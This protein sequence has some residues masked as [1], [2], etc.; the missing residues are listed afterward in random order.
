M[1]PL[2]LNGFAPESW[3]HH[4]LLSCAESAAAD[5]AMAAAGT[6]GLELMRRAA[7]AV[8]NVVRKH[9]APRPT[10]V[11]CGP[12]NNGGDGFIIAENLRQA[13]WLVRVYCIADRTKYS[14]DAAQALA[15]WQGD[16]VTF[17]PEDTQLVVDALFG[18]GLNK[19][20]EGE[21]REAIEKINARGLDVV[22]VDIPSGIQGD[23]G[24][25][26][27]AA[28]KARQ[29][30]TFT[31]KKIGHLL[32]PGC[33]LAGDVCVAD[34][35]I[36][37]AALPPSCA[38]NM[39]GL[40]G[41][42][43]PRPGREQHKYDRGHVL[44]LG[45]EVL[46]GAARLAARAAQRGGAGLVT[47]AAPEKAWP[48][49]AAA[50]ES[51]M[52]R[53]MVSSGDWQKLLEDRR[54]NTVVLGPGAGVSEQTYARVA[55]ALTLGK[56]C[57]LDADALTAFRDDPEELF[58]LLNPACVLTPHEGEFAALFGDLVDQTRDKL[59]RARA[60]ARLAGCPVLLKGADTV[61]AAPTGQAVINSNAPAWL[62]VGGAGD[63]LS[64]L[65]A[66]LLAQGME[67]FAAAAAAAWLH[68]AAA[69]Q[70]GPGMIPEELIASLPNVG[71][72]LRSA[73]GTATPARCVSV[74][75][76]PK[77]P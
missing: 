47:I 51:V 6:A 68:G 23:S 75:E 10:L 74:L 57:V 30:V 33:V 63:V 48:V 2:R 13:G 59:H 71:N 66:A 61:I 67:S 42:L 72:V 73:T 65:I 50:L 41:H 76:N 54:K 37:V 26:M 4:A 62:A 19:P 53:P 69:G 31:R 77:N 21:A 46:T 11:V 52:V 40:W 22:A 9:Y 16:F 25:V 3:N 34:I 27:G 39:P 35:G 58:D 5:R 44:V 43:L 24:A 56:A 1:E 17:L 18:T 64:G 36:V 49:Y 14:G 20:I 38:E 45:G 15:G 70:H 29:T 28:L 32:L 12:G 8:V 55:H 60:A 7:Q